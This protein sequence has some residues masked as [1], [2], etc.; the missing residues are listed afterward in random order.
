[1]LV[2]R[3]GSFRRFL[4]RSL[5]LVLGASLFFL[6]SL[7]V[8]QVVARVVFDLGMIWHSDVVSILLPAMGWFGAAY[9]WLVRQHVVVDVIIGKQQRFQSAVLMISDCMILIG[10]YWCFPKVLKTIIEYDVLYMPV[11]PLPASV[12]YMPIF[13][14]LILLTL[15]AL[16]N[17]VEY[18]FQP[19]EEKL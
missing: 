6:V 10:M 17:L 7:E 8:A 15:A 11:L 9:L 13:C 4:E 2:R 19:V 14:A 1:M 3:L 5:I 12:V 18:L 16:I